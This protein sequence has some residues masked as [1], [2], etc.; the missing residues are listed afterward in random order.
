M[1]IPEMHSTVVVLPAPF[2][3]MI[4]KISPS[5]TENDTSITPTP[6]PY[7]LRNRSTV[8]T[9]F[10]PDGPRA[11]VRCCPA[12]S[13]GAGSGPLGVLTVMPRGSCR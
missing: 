3:P 4:P 7:A 8:T 2:G 10:V 5:L 13:I 6:R 9:G 12:S 1:R 11:A